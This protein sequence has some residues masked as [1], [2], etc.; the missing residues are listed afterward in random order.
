MAQG[1]I[2]RLARSCTIDG[3]LNVNVMHFIETVTTPLPEQALIDAWQGTGNVEAYVKAFQNGAESWVNGS[4]TVQRISP[5]KGELAEAPMN[6]SGLPALVAGLPTF[7]QIAVRINTA[8]NSRSGR[9]RNYFGGVPEAQTIGNV[10]TAGY[11]TIITDYMD[12][13]NDVFAS[14]GADF[15]GFELGV[16]SETLQQFNVATSLVVGSELGTMVS[17]RLGRGV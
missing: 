1:D 11:Q 5:T 4:I 8:L 9:G 10:I 7:A 15:S 12:R 3:V 17:R 13:M 14:G 6:S 2:Y 16:W